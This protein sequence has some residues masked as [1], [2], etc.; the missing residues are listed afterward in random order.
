MA[1]DDE[2][3][4]GVPGGAVDGVVDG[5][6]C[7]P[8]WLPQARRHD[9]PRDPQFGGEHLRRRADVRH[10]VRAVC[11]A[12]QGRQPAD[13][14]AELAV[15]VILDHQRL[16][17]AGPLDQGGP[18][19]GG[20]PRA[21]R[22]L[23]RR[24]RVHGSV[25]EGER[26]RVEAVVVDGDRTDD[27][28]GSLERAASF[29]IPGFFECHPASRQVGRDNQRAQR[30]GHA[31]NEDDVAGAGGD[32]AGPAQMQCECFL[33]RVMR[34]G[35][36]QAVRHGALG[37]RPPRRPPVAGH[38]QAGVRI[39]GQQGPPG[40]PSRIRPAPGGRRRRRDMRGH[41]G[42]S[43]EVGAGRHDGRRACRRMN[44]TRRREL[45]IGGH[46]RRPGDA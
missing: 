31:G 12:V 33:R 10:H 11:Q 21:E 8:Y 43:G 23:V 39:T 26:G 17:P 41:P 5:G 22:V 20:Q 45:V 42:A 19:G 14:I 30:G 2:V 18:A 6:E 7:L 32:A 38:D 3:G 28:P 13:V 1:R 24:S 40:C 9:E 15:V 36:R 34:L 25:A 27:G 44:E 35:A 29:G 46:H 16:G 4:E 37:R